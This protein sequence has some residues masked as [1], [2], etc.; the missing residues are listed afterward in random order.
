MDIYALKLLYLFVSA[1]R[2]TSAKN[3]N[4]CT[5]IWIILAI[6]VLIFNVII[7]SFEF[8]KDSY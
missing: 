2:I 6:T 7:H 3:K 5:D 1:L 8:T 4:H